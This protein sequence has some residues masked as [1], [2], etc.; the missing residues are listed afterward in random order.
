MAFDEGLTAR[1]REALEG[2]PGLSE[3]RMM[4]GICFL[5]DGNMIAGADRT[6]DGQGRFLFRVGREHQ[7]AALA[8]PGAQLM[9]MG[10]RQ[11]R[12]FIFV[13]EEACDAAAMRSWCALALD[14]VGTLPPKDEAGS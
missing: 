6:R 10:G 3:K 12:G 4:G 7:A 11:M 5:L 14:F 2:L 13:D 9:E 1:L 8:R